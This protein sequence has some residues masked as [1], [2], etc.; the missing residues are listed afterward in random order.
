MTLELVPLCTAQVTL[1]SPIVLPAT[2][3]GMRIIG[4]VTAITVEGPRVRATLRGAAAA[5]WLLVAPDGTFGTID[6]RVTLETDDEALILMQY[7]G[8]LDLAQSPAVATVAPRFDTG[9][10]RYAWLARLQAVARGTFNADM[11]QL[12]YEMFELRGG[13][14]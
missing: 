7:N 14:S 2:P 3:L 8:R 10:E 4:E 9:D 1:A 5:D 13:A 6:A 12:T 11:S